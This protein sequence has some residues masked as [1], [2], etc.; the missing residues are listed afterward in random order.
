[1]NKQLSS[2]DY[3]AVKKEL[4]DL[5]LPIDPAECH[6]LLTGFIIVN[7]SVKL[8]VGRIF[9]LLPMN[10]IQEKDLEK[11]RNSIEELGVNVFKQLTDPLLSLRLLL[12]DDSAPIQARSVATGLW[13]E[14][15]LYGLGEAGL[16]FDNNENSEILREL[17]EDLSAISQ[18][19]TQDVAE[20]EEYEVA[21]AELEEYLRIAAFTI[22]TEL[23]LQ[24]NE[25]PL[26]I[27]T[28]LQ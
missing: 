22:Y 14:G 10:D 11:L 4:F 8:A 1:M 16:R 2:P 3:Y 7:P 24:N 26:E 28:T 15:F 17:I 13:C 21:L 5:S 19:D 9:D 20:T 25:N 12:P 6:G 27:R 18:I 23:Q